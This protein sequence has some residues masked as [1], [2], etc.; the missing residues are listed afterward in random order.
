M[1]ENL[2]L[3]RT[4]LEHFSLYGVMLEEMGFTPAP[5]P[6]PSLPPPP[7]PPASIVLPI[8]YTM[9][10]L[11]FGVL[12]TGGAVWQ[13]MR[14]RER[15]RLRVVAFEEAEKQH[16]EPL[17]SEARDAM[18]NPC[19]R[20]TSCRIFERPHLGAA[21]LTLGA[22]MLYP[23]PASH[24]DCDSNSVYWSRREIAAEE[25]F[26]RPWWDAMKED[27]VQEDPIAEEKRRRK[28]DKQLRCFAMINPVRAVP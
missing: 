20:T 2:R 6:T 8:V 1:D 16:H 11:V 21:S 17:R 27:L 22:R 10:G 12:V 14:F 19:A 9:G 18:Q 3:V 4:K 7:P 26:D 28:E 23:G 25:D 5:T 15:H 24:A 13:V